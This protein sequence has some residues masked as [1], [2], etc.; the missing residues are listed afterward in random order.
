MVDATRSG[1]IFSTAAGDTPSRGRTD[2]SFA[3][4]SADICHESRPSTCSASCP[5]FNSRTVRARASLRRRRA[6]A[7]PRSKA[8]AS[9]VGVTMRSTVFAETVPLLV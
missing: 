6:T 8:G 5:S 3:R 7:M 4:A 2:S 1:R 9:F